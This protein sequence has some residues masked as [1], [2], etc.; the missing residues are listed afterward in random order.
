MITS[1]SHLIGFCW[2]LKGHTKNLTSTS[3]VVIV[4]TH[5][6]AR[7]YLLRMC[8]VG[9]DSVVNVD[10]QLS[11]VLDQKNMFCA[12]WMSYL[13]FWVFVAICMVTMAKV[14]RQSFALES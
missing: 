1:K 11:K 4:I 13:C 14:E 6:F 8:Y 7:F 2:P 10:T 3:M 5:F 9:K 12:I